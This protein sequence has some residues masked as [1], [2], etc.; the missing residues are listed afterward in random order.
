MVFSA[1]YNNISAISRQSVLL[2]EETREPGENYWP[3]ASHWQTLP[4]NVVSS[5]PGHEKGS[6]SQI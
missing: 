5:T 1:T 3:V 2:A 4:H 6:N